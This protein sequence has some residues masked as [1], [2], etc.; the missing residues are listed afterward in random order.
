MQKHIYQGIISN[1]YYVQARDGNSA[2]KSK[3]IRLGGNNASK[4]VND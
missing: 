1:E 4:M 2:E 3:H